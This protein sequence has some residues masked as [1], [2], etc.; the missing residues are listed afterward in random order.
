MLSGDP[1]DAPW[2]GR[3][4]A[5]SQLPFFASPLALAVGVARGAAAAATSARTSASASPASVSRHVDHQFPLKR[6]APHVLRRPRPA[7]PP[8]R[9]RSGRSSA[10]SPPRRPPGRSGSPCASVISTATFR[11]CLFS[12]TPM[13]FTLKGGT[14]GGV[15]SVGSAAALAA[16]QEAAERTRSRPASARERGAE[17][18]HVALA[19]RRPSPCA[20]ASIRARSMTRHVGR[21]RSSTAPRGLR[22]L[23]AGSGAWAAPAPTRSHQ[24]QAEAGDQSRVIAGGPSPFGVG[25]S[26]DSEV[27]G[28]ALFTS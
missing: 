6:D 14:G 12:R 2:S 5:R 16:E 21:L 28:E 20:G 10:G 8:T 3:A 19:L 11:P 9:G 18:E 17:L 1:A 22:R 24:R 7:R 4:T 27:A 13:Y 23:A 15:G 25:R 26:R